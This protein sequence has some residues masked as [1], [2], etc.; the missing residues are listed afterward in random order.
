[1]VKVTALHTVFLAL[2]SNIEPRFTNLQKAMESIEQKNIIIK[3]R[4]PIYET[5]PWGFLEQSDF[6]NMV[7]ICECNTAPTELIITL[8]SIEKMMGRQ[9]TIKNG[10]RN[11]DIDILLFD[12]L[13]LCTETLIIPH[14]R[15]TERTF[16]MAP[17]NDLT[18]D[19]IIPG[20]DRT[21]SEVYLAIGSDG[22]KKWEQ[23][24]V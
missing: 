20:I 6:L 12:Q 10:P 4:S 8:K 22:I 3:Q 24:V 23:L 18:P 9:K 2:G 21:V 1:M 16:V 19:L 15:L 5:K 7:I 13:K 14:P 11:I 17:L